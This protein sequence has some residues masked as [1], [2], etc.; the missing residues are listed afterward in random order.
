[1]AI[2]SA[3]G[4][5]VCV[6]GSLCVSIENHRKSFDFLGK[7]SGKSTALIPGTTLP[8]KSTMGAAA[9]WAVRNGKYRI[10]NLLCGK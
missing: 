6:V 1:M 7:F 2:I 9:K 8:A 5:G 10:A 3:V 4:R